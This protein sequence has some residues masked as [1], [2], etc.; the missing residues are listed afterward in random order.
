MLQ[1]LTNR[2]KTGRLISEITRLRKV[3]HEGRV[4]AVKAEE[5]T[6]KSF[7][8]LFVLCVASGNVVNIDCP[9]H[10]ACQS[11]FKVI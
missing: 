2:V 1:F 4:D 9:S 3:L 7:N 8:I 10:L 11:P 6:R 5:I